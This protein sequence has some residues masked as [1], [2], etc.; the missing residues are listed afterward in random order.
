M[1][2]TPLPNAE[3]TPLL[4]WTL[5]FLRPYRRRVALLT[6]LLL[7][8][9]GLGA[10]APWP[11]AVVI[12]HVL[13]GK[14]FQGGITPWPAIDGYLSQAKAALTHNNQ[15]AFLILVVIARRGAAGGE[16]AGVGL[17]HA[18]AGRHRP[19]DG[20]RPAVPAVSASDGARPPPS[21]HHQH[22][23]CGVPGRRRC[24]RDREPGDE[25]H[26]SARDVDHVAGGH[27]RRPVVHERHDRVVVARGRA[28]S[29]PLSPLLHVHAGG[30][31]RAGEGARIEAARAAVR[32]LRRD[33]AGEE[34]RARA[35]RARAL[36]AGRRE[37]DGRADCD[38]L[39]AVAVRGH[40]QHHHDPRHR[41]GRDR[42]RHAGDARRADR[43][44][45]VRGHQLSGRGVR[46]A[47]GDRAH[48]RQ[49][50][51]RAGRRQAGP[52]D[53]R[54]DPRDRRGAR[55]GPRERRSRAT[56]AS[57]TSASSTPTAPA[58]STTSRFPRSPA[59]WSRWSA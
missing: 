57:R 54:A 3:Q 18:G 42:R 25:R 53:V 55:R 14:P 58:S 39:A 13:G 40:R 5:S 35:A 49:S 37:D 56:S 29:L 28:V 51:R 7:T 4:P 20:L 30:A 48:H 24:L 17:R 26:L 31:G 45:V 12:D 50:S 44:P 47:V 33:A 11:L 43:R 52:G 27:V 32:N 9:I 46:T 41:A 1:S 59:R 2:Q 22:G 36:C 21:H 10:L 23:G 6:V 34:L 19:A 15:L 16:P 38:H 8:E